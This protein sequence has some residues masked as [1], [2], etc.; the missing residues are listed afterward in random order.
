MVA[1]TIH[2]AENGPW[3]IIRRNGNVVRSNVLL[4]LIYDSR[5]EAERAVEKLRDA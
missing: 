3:F 2:P 4:P 5:E 1:L